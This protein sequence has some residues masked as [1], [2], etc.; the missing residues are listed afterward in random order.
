M[1]RK[2]ML[3]VA[4]KVGGLLRGAIHQPGCSR[5]TVFFPRQVDN[6]AQVELRFRTIYRTRS[7][8][9]VLLLR[10]LRGR[11]YVAVGVIGKQAACGQPEKPFLVLGALYLLLPCLIF[12]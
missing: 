6:N 7:D 2:V 12:G 1:T 9:M 3:F 11:H 10:R 4:R 8:R 5:Q